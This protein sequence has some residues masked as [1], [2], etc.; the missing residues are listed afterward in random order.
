[1]PAT[2]NQPQVFETRDALTDCE[3]THGKIACR[4]QGSPAGDLEEE[5]G[6]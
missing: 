2:T 1:M 4:F 5:R 3:F 6:L